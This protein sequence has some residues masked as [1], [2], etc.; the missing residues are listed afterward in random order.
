MMGDLTLSTDPDAA[1]AYTVFLDGLAV[2][3]LEV[4]QDIVETGVRR[5]FLLLTGRRVSVRSTVTAWEPKK[6][7]ISRAGVGVAPLELEG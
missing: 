1:G 7:L 5:V 4:K 2:G 3:R 6:V